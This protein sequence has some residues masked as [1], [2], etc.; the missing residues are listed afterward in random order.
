M[1]DPDDR[2]KNLRDERE[3]LERD[4]ET[5]ESEELSAEERAAALGRPFPRWLA[6]GL[7]IAAVLS[8]AFLF[9]QYGGKVIKTTSQSD[10][11]AAV[12]RPAD[13]QTV[14]APATNSPDT[15]LTRT[16]GQMA[17]KDTAATQLEA[18]SQAAESAVTD[19][20][21]ASLADTTLPVDQRSQINDQF[22][23]LLNAQV[24]DTETVA[25]EDTEF[26]RMLFTPLIP[27]AGLPIPINVPYPA[28]G[29][30]AG[31]GMAAGVP[32]DSTRYML[33]ID[34]LRSE[35]AVYHEQLE[36][37][38]PETTAALAGV[39]PEVLTA[40]DT[41]RVAEIKKLAKILESMDPKAAAVMLN[42]RSS[43]ELRAVLFKVKPRVAAKIVENLPT[44]KRDEFAEFIVHR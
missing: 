11:S 43:D 17:P 23:L 42:G 38:T 7:G 39:K 25:L 8:V 4:P 24:S 35:L 19:T 31:A 44:G 26:V 36:R 32:W 37:V 34:S 18:P 22:Y 12:G 30:L 16:A 9:W 1:V 41:A 33:V 27:G 20:A 14:V 13:S 2:P 21:L 6:M 15:T 10:T 29:E 40:A 3:E 28:P 5:E